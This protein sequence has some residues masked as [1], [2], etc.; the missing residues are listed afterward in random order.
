MKK[1]TLGII[2]AAVVVIGG[3]AYVYYANNTSHTTTNNQTVQGH[4][5]TVLP[6]KSNPIQNTATL[7]GLT[8]TD[9]QV[10]NNT[11]PATGNPVDDRL[12]FTIHNSSSQPV[13]NLE[14]YYTMTDTKT[15]KSES[16]YQ[17]LDGITIEPGK[18]TTVFFDNGTGVGHYPDNKYS[19]YR[20]SQNAVDFSIEVSATGLKPATA[21]AQ[22]GSG[23]GDTKD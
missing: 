22:K 3:G 13:Q 11:D 14:V 21:Q 23:S 15:Q 6:V 16:Y 4:T 9:A 12:Q 5:P 17:K 2:I 7:A 10:E 20:T 8:V 19:I 1:S 18:S